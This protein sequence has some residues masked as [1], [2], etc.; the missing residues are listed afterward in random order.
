MAPDSFGVIRPDVWLAFFELHWFCR[1]RLCY[2]SI[3][4]GPGF[5]WHIGVV[6][7]WRVFFP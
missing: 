7:I 6:Q 1:S 2:M 4:V 5:I 3:F